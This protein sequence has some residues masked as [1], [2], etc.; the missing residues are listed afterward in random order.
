MLTQ[1]TGYFNN[2]F[3][4][5][6]PMEKLIAVWLHLFRQF[7]LN[8]R[9]PL[10]ELVSKVCEYS[11]SSPWQYSFK[12][13]S[14]TRVSYDFYHKVLTFVVQPEYL[15]SQVK[16]HHP[17]TGEVSLLNAVNF[18]LCRLASGDSI[19]KTA[20][21]VLQSGKNPWA[22]M[23]HWLLHSVT[24]PGNIEHQHIVFS[25]Q[26]NNYEFGSF[27]AQNA[28]AWHHFAA[29][30]VKKFHVFDID[31]TIEPYAN[32]YWSAMKKYNETAN[33]TL[34]DI[35]QCVLDL[36][37][38]IDFLKATL[39]K[40]LFILPFCVFL[41]SCISTMLELLLEHRLVGITKTI[42]TLIFNS[43]GIIIAASLL[44]TLLPDSLVSCFELLLSSLGAATLLS[45]INIL[46]QQATLISFVTMFLAIAFYYIPGFTI[47]TTLISLLSLAKAKQVGVDTAIFI[48]SVVGHDRT[49]HAA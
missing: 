14:L 20:T 12:E 39:L 31:K 30:N 10:S 4:L 42:K 16:T 28:D 37:N 2:R 1:V 40:E 7:P 32:S 21:E 9:P 23:Q 38:E 45:Q 25:R 49:P 13:K 43:M 19:N 34:N 41:I 3:I 36:T 11:V 26:P 35:N 8:E 6:E 33:A 18:R 46:S 17:V 24:D 5:S 15:G 44:N 48:L 22:E 47:L 27:L 29:Q